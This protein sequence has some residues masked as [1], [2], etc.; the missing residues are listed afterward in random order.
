MVYYRPQRSWGKVIFSQASVILSTGGGGIPAC[1]AGGI[2]ACLAAG[3]VCAIPVC[4]AGGIPVCL[5]AGGVCYPSIPCSRGGAC[6]W[7]VPG[8][9]GGA[10]SGRVCS[11][12]V[13]G[14][15]F[16]PGRPLLQAE[17]ILLECILVLLLRLREKNRKYKIQGWKVYLF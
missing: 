4:I 2:P 11:Q 8:L 15:D 1:I 7:G 16:P 17:R 9:G 6:S 12:G 13:P 5:A 14:G 10:W 3:G